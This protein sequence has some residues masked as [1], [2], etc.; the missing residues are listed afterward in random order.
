MS[1]EPT[2]PRHTTKGHSIIYSGDNKRIIYDSDKDDFKASSKILSGD[3]K[4]VLHE[5][6]E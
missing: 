5:S 6:K 3:G 4:R 2:Q 1:G